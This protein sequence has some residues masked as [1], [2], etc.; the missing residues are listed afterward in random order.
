MFPL[1]ARDPALTHE[2]VVSR[3]PIRRPAPTRRLSPGGGGCR[4][5]S[6]RPLL[7]AAVVGVGA[8]VPAFVGLVGDGQV[9]AGAPAWLK[10]AKFALSIAIY[11]ATLSWLLTL[12]RGHRRVVQTVG[13]L[14]GVALIAELALI[15]LQVLRGTTS[16]FNTSTPTDAVILAAMGALVALV[17]L[18][19]LATA[20][21]LI[22]QRGLRPT[23]AG[24]GTPWEH[25]TVGPAC[26]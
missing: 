1:R 23:T 14:T 17:F 19:A 12:V 9:I 16:H 6:R 11:C 25:R 22:R 5:Q 24:V 21:L 10:P 18:A 2:P 20:G 7:A 26:H 8:L 13:W 3:H 4:E 15:D